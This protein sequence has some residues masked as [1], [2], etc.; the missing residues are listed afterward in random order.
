MEEVNL[1][2][3]VTWFRENKCES[4]V[5]FRGTKRRVT[6]VMNRIGPFLKTCGGLENSLLP[7]FTNE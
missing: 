2:T 4:T 3:D 1:E 5:G 6:K 7:Y